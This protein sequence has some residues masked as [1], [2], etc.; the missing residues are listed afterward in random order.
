MSRTLLLLL[1]AAALLPFLAR[2]EA[3]PGPFG[4]SGSLT[5]RQHRLA[6]VHAK[7]SGAVSITDAVWDDGAVQVRLVDG[8]LVPLQATGLDVALGFWFEGTC[9]LTVR[10]HE[11][12]RERFRRAFGGQ[13][14]L[15][16]P[17]TRVVRYGSDQDAIA[18]LF[19]QGTPLTKKEA[20][21]VD[22]SRVG[23]VLERT[24]SPI[25]IIETHARNLLTWSLGGHPELYEGSLRFLSVSGGKRRTAEETAVSAVTLLESPNLRTPDRP[26]SL[27]ISLETPQGRGTVRLGASE[28]AGRSVSAAANLRV[29]RASLDLGL[30]P[31][32]QLWMNVEGTATW[33]L[34][35]ET[36]PQSAAVFVLRGPDPDPGVG[37]RIVSVTDGEGRSLEFVHAQDQLLVVFEEALLPGGTEEITVRWAGAAAGRHGNGPE[38]DTLRPGF[39]WPRLAV[40]A[41]SPFALRVCTPADLAVVASGRAGEVT[42]EGKRTCRAWSSETATAAPAVVVG[43]WTTSE[44]IQVGDIVARVHTPKSEDD[45]LVLTDELPRALEFLQEMFGPLPWGELNLVRTS[46]R[47]LL[48]EPSPGVVPYFATVAE[49]SV[50]HDVSA[51]EWLLYSLAKQWTSGVLH[52]RGLEDAWLSESVAMY[53]TERYTQ[54]HLPQIHLKTNHGPSW[55][56]VAA[57]TMGRASLTDIDI[58]GAQVQLALLWYRGPLVVSALRRRVGDKAFAGWLGAL[59]ARGGPTTTE[60]AIAQYAKASSDEDLRSFAEALV[61]RTDLPVL[62]VRVEGGEMVIEQLQDGP[63]FELVI[64]VRKAPIS[65]MTEVVEVHMTSRIARVPVDGDYRSVELDPLATVP[66]VP[67]SWLRPKEGIFDRVTK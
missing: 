31:D 36:L 41:P 45:Q 66:W 46:A 53:A 18:A 42:T 24:D 23:Y 3:P 5:Q 50:L 22:P 67:A 27:S 52:P 39:S 32:L 38:Y 12:G 21:R 17:C 48:S 61:S 55:Q 65:G 40:A 44:P 20:S 62:D 2:A 1:V 15:T 37:H 25:P 34:T 10:P 33:S 63:P 30:T 51:V 59:V 58:V 13:T 11:R 7:T 6:R 56:A 29:E 9:E 28:P 60:E 4:M 43:K 49:G 8:H 19:D 14:S 35:A 26:V 54:R 57:Q 16:G 47:A 64:P